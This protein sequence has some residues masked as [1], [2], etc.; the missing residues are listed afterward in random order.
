MTYNPEEEEIFSQSTNT[1]GIAN[2]KYHCTNY[3]EQDGQ[4]QQHVINCLKQKKIKNIV[5]SFKKQNP[6]FSSKN[7]QN[8]EVKFKL[9]CLIFYH[10]WKFFVATLLHLAKLVNGREGPEFRTN[11][12]ITVAHLSCYTVPEKETSLVLKGW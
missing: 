3:N 9:Y 6:S 10:L 12:T 4:I 7:K 8:E 11:G 2:N 1:A 5:L